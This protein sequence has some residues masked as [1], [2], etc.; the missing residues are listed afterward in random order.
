MARGEERTPEP[1]SC[2]EEP[3]SQRSTASP[4]RF[5]PRPLLPKNDNNL[6]RPLAESSHQV[7][8]SAKSGALQRMLE[9]LSNLI[10]GK[11]DSA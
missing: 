11:A 8:A 3:G 1:G 4:F 10:K 9:H 7:T 6:G 5:S 2:E